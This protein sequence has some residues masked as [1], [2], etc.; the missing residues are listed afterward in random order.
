MNRPRKAKPKVNKQL[1]DHLAALGR[2]GGA[3]RA[4][5]LTAQERRRIAQDA[6]RTRWNPQEGNE[7]E[8]A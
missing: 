2:K 6:A 1:S 3:A 7:K 8:K 4:K 5:K